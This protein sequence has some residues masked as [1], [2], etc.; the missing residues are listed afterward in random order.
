MNYTIREIRKDEIKLLDNFL[1]QAIYIPEGVEPPPFEIIQKPELQ[2]Y[3][4][5]FGTRKADFCLIA[6][7][8]NKIIGAVWTRIMQ[9]YGHIDNQ[10]PS[11]AISLYKEYRNKKIGTNLMIK[12]LELLKTKHYNRVSLSVQKQNY[13][14]K[15]YLKVGFKVVD[16]NEEEYI[17]KW[18][19][20]NK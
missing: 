3:V 11:L 6:E 8:D 12:I 13:A 7:I 20:N 15:M 17:M 19:N 9:D 5:N 4:E 2:V 16:E 10:T 18:E 14:Y 1:Y